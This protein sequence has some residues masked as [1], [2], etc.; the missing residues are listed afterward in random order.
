MVIAKVDADAERTLGERFEVKGFPTLKWFPKGSTTPEEYTGGRDAEGIV[1]FVNDKAGLSRRVKKT[2]SAVVTLTPA[3]FD[4]VVNGDKDVLVKFYAP[5]CG[6]CKTLAPTFDTV[7]K[8][9]AGEAGVV[10]AKVD[11]SEHRELGSR[12]DVSGFP[13]L[14]FFA[15]GDTAGAAY[16]GGRGVPDFVSFL[17]EKAGTAYTPEGGLKASYGRLEAL[18]KLVADGALRWVV[19]DERRARLLCMCRSVDDVR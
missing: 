18:D 6:H 4:A 14:K 3:N 5:W 10:V 7:A 17:N 9:F 13:T 8:I 2:P 19:C 11:A 1:K 12:F 15:K 16:E